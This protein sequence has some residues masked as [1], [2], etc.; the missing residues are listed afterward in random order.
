MWIGGEV[1]IQIGVEHVRRWG[2]VRPHFNAH[3]SG[4]S[5]IRIRWI[6]V[7][8]IASAMDR[9]VRDLSRARGAD[10]S[11]SRPKSEALIASPAES[12]AD[13]GRGPRRRP[14][15]DRMTRHGTCGAAP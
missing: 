2:E 1:E 5:A 14:G 12:S 3:T 7:P 9:Q 10:G 11:L 13:L 8:R 4:A 15:V 6:V